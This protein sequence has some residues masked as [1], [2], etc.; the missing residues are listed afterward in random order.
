[1]FIQKAIETLLADK[2]IK[3]AAHAELKATC[4][5]VLDEIKALNAGNGS[6]VEAAARQSRRLMGPATRR[7]RRWPSCRR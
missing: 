6:N 4:E 3:R 7:R 1:M 5:Q 2:D